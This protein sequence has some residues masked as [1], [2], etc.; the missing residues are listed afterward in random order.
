MRDM[1]DLTICSS[2]DSR[3]LLELRTANAINDHGKIVGL[4]ANKLDGTLRAFLAKRGG[5][6]NPLPPYQVSDLGALPNGGISYALALNNA[7]ATVGAAYLDA[8]G[9]GNNVAALFA[10][11]RVVNLHDSLGLFDRLSWD[12]K[13]ATG[14]N[15]NGEIVGWGVHEG[16]I[17]AFKLTPKAHLTVDGVVFPPN[18]HT[19]A[20]LGID[21]AG[22][23]KNG[24]VKV[25]VHKFDIG[26][27]L[28]K[29]RSATTGAT[30][31]FAWGATVPCGIDLAVSAWDQT[32]GIYSNAGSIN[33]SCYGS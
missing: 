24:I 2:G 20:V 22:F 11:D 3:T 27:T 6:C 28:V 19:R 13:E 33:I 1:N 8:S 5:S 31:S 15:D 18:Q 21:G 29:S 7:D 17:R 25:E 4:A 32:T 12:L 14:I 23:S 26:G 30:G 9:I 10:H 16:Q